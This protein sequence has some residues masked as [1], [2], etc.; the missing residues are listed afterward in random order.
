[1][2]GRGGVGL[3]ITYSSVNIKTLHNGWCILKN[4]PVFY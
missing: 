2:L 1:M 3:D 4:M